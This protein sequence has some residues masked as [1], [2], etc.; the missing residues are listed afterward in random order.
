MSM[1]ALWKHPFLFKTTFSSSDSL[2]GA[3]ERREL[4]PL[5][6]NMAYLHWEKDEMQHDFA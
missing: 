2:L 3:T 1:S 5:D 6:V 4:K